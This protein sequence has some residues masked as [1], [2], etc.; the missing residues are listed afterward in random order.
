ME[1][2]SKTEYNKLVKLDYEK[3][4]EAISQ[5]LKKSSDKSFDHSEH[6]K[7][8]VKK[9]VKPSEDSMLITKI[10]DAYISFLDNKDE[11]I[12]LPKFK[13]YFL[14]NKIVKDK[15]YNEEKNKYYLKIVYKD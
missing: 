3:F 1:K 12:T 2:I 6:I 7:K 8:F 9:H 13:E 11:S 14:A 4:C 5:T 10:K 15:Y